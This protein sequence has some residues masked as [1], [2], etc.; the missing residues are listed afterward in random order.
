MRAILTAACLAALGPAPA[1]AAN[2]EDQIAKYVGE[3]KSKDAATRRAA[4]EEIGKIGRVKASA[5]KPAVAPLLDLLMDKDDGVRTAAATALSRLDEPQV[6]VPALTKLLKD[7][8][9]VRVRVAA[10][11]GL[12]LMGEAARSALPALRDAR[13]E[14]MATGRNAQPLAQAAGQ[15]IQQ[16]G[17]RKKP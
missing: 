6:V 9:R 13:R 1:G 12:G 8:G 7:D 5:A 10:A 4:T 15:A 14:A 3:L 17:N 2:L 11:N 16:I